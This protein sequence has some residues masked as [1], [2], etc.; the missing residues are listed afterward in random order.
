MA[1]V[2]I[3]T[4]NVQGLGGISKR[5]DILEYLKSMNFD[6]YCIQDTHFTDRDEIL[7]REQWNGDCI[8]SNF[9]SNARGVAILFGN[10]IEFKVHKKIIDDQG[11]FIILDITLQNH[12]LS[13]I[14]IYG[15]NS[16]S[17][18]FFDEIMKHIGEIGNSDFIICG[19]FNIS[20]DQRKDCFNYKHV[21]NPKA[22]QKLVDLIET[23]NII[24]PFRELYPDLKRYTWRRKTPL[25]Q[26]RLDYFL[27]S[28][29]FMQF[30]KQ[31]EIESSYRSDHSPVIM[32]M[33]FTN[34]PHGKSYWK[35]NNSLL[36]DREYL[37]IMTKK[38]IDIKRQYA[39]PVYNLDEIEN[40]PDSELCFTIDDQLFLEILLMELRG[41]SISYASY[42]NKQKNNREKEL[43]NDIQ[44]LEHNMNESNKE[45]VDKLKTE[46]YE[47]RQDKLKGYIIRSRAQYIDK[48]E[49]PTKYFCGLEKHNYV[50][51]TIQQLEKPD[52]TIL[53]EQ[54]EIL[55]ETEMYYS[56]LYRSRDES[57]DDIDI[58]KYIGESMIKL[59][60]E[61]A[62]NLEGLLTLREISDV[63]KSMKNE[64]S[65]GLSGFSAEFFKVFWKQLSNFVLRSLNLGYMKGELSVTQKQGIITCIP[66]ENKPKQYLKNWRP[67]T[68]LDTV[69]K[70]AS[71]AIANRIKGV[72]DFI[73]LRDQTGFLKGRSMVENIR[74]IYDIMKY[75]E[76]KHIQGMLLLIDFEKAFDS[77]SWNF[78]HKALIH[79]NFGE[80]IRQWINVFYTGITSAVNLSGH[81]SPF[82]N[83]GRGCRQGDPLSPYLFIICAEFL[84]SKI[85]HNTKIKG[86]CINSLEF[87]ISQFAD[88][89]SVIL[90]GTE[91]SLNE[92][93]EELENFA[94]IS[95]LNVNFDK[96]QLVW[97]GSAKYSTK[98]IKTKWKLSW[99]KTTFKL[100]GVN[101]NINLEKMIQDNF[102]LKITQMK[103]VIKSWEKR[104]LSPLGKIT[105]IKTLIL[106][107]F[108]HLFTSIPNPDQTVL[109]TINEILYDFLW[110]KKAKIKATIV[111]KQYGDG[112]L[113]M[114]NL[115]A[116]INALKATWIRRL[117]LT[118]CK[119][120]CFI[121][122]YI[123]IEKMTSCNTNYVEKIVGNVKNKFWKDVLLSFLEIDRKL[124]LSED[125]V[126]KSP[127][128]Y[129]RN[130]TVG[131]ICTFYQT[132]H[133]KGLV[134]LNDLIK[135]NCH[136]YT[137][138]EVIGKIGISINLLQYQGLV[139]SVKAYLKKIKVTLSHK[140]KEPFIPSH[141]QPFLVQQT[142][143][144]TLYNILN[145][146]NAIPTSKLAWNEKYDIQ[147][148]E[149]KSIFEFPFKIT[150][151]PAI[152]WFQ[153]CI[154]HNIL[155]TNSL[156]FKMKLKA[157]PLCY[158][159][160]QQKET[161]TH[162]FWSC[163]IVQ[164]FITNLQ[165][166]LDS[167]NI[168]SDISEKSFIFGVEKS[169]SKTLNSIV[170]YAKYYIYITRCNQQILHLDV[171]KKK[172]LQFYKIHMEIYLSN[173][174]LEEFYEDWKP[175]QSLINSIR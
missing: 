145:K 63:L 98:S 62:I 139:S 49:K 160:H 2:N 125:Q 137:H 19:D 10:K 77:L 171:Y 84:A 4:Y 175:F 20:L 83:I 60:N 30:I 88:D 67:L 56:N 147:E 48:G 120:R 146:N 136:F 50:S 169:I 144:Q 34:F 61:Q 75:T 11:N 155:V 9:R 14:N 87:K 72:L 38:I 116:F 132:W 82:F 57:L 12:R 26:A 174:K 45:E 117:L 59:T 46:L 172:L 134:F 167:F 13:L 42:K 90:D 69:Y 92:A 66:K 32:R 140:E 35:H 64:K 33:V 104:N 152:Q 31:V 74:V 97:I 157:D 111:V 21:N 112:G 156:L 108:N 166:W 80:S 128:F 123:D 149:W 17:P 99:G 106:P 173:N 44:E 95:G 47:I 170:L 23:Y 110:N 29:G 73:I 102:S 114:I 133:K 161:I 109:E 154:N 3:V 39:L 85:R 18:S 158:Y 36:M 78:L 163:S 131:G 94:K 6:I 25:K 119:W 162:L 107:I 130:I 168:N 113:K 15:P 22:R 58:H 76:D 27:T 89:T 100:L 115:K 24:D 101:F 53:I 54:K 43:M 148:E 1:D 86:I 118:D 65:P 81:L 129:N 37:N 126:L 70:L 141:I 150:K 159:C 79:L 7:I 151:Y 52:G 28:E 122:Q 135:E 96:T 142:G 121:K 153:T 8:F 51:K 93:L 124:E 55:K 91:Q 40:I 127:L 138:Q 103:K 16:D 164:Q 71:G 105:V 5:M 41:Q 143:A 165:G 68:L